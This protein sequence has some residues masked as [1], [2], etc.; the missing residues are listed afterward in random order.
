MT[1]TRRAVRDAIVSCLLVSAA[2]A[3]RSQDRHDPGVEPRH[4]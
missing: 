4:A 3:E 1:M 2:Q